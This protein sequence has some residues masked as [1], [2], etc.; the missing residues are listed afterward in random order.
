[1]PQ[2]SV[3]IAMKR[4]RITKGVNILG[5]IITTKHE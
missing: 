4:E 3:A 2:L 5:K 1:M